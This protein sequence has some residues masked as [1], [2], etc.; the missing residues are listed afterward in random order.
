VELLRSQ[1]SSREP[2]LF[3]LR[4][5]RMAENPFAF[6]LSDNNDSDETPTGSFDW[7]VRQPLARVVVGQRVTRR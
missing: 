7:D 3:P 1:E 5:A 6:L 2:T 4:Y